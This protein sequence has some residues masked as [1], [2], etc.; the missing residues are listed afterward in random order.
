LKKRNPTLAES[1]L[2]KMFSWQTIS[3]I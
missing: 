2:W 1:K 3:G